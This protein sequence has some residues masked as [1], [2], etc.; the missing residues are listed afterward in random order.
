[1]RRYGF[2]I[3]SYAYFMTSIIPQPKHQKSLEGKF[4]LLENASISASAAARAKAEQLAN[5]LRPATGFALPL[6]EG[7]NGTIYLELDEKIEGAEAYELSVSSLG[8]QLKASSEAGL[9]YAIQSLRQLLPTSI[10]N[11]SKVDTVWS[12]PCLEIE[13]SP[14]FAWRGTH[15]DVSRHFMPL[16]FVKKFIDLMALHK[17]NVFHWHLTDDQG[18][19]LESKKYPRL[20]EVGA[21]RKQTMI[22]HGMQENPEFDGVPHGG[23]YTQDEAREIV[24]YG[25]ERHVT[26]M[27]EIELPGHAQAALAA[28]PEFGNTGEKLEVWGKWGI[29]ENVFNPLEPTILFLQEILSEV[30]SIFPSH[31]IHVGGD[32]CPKTQWE[33]SAAA[34]KRMRE[35]EI[36]DE[37]ALQSYFIG[38]MDK[39][40]TSKGRRLVGWDEILEGGLTENATVMSWRGEDGGIS[41]A[42]A[43]HDVIMTP[44]SHTY[45]DHYQSEQTE[46]EPLAIGGFTP[47][48]KVYAYEPIPPQL[49]ALEARHVLGSQAQHW[50][51]YMQVPSHVEYMAFPRLC[52]FGEVVWS[53]QS[54]RNYQDFL[55]RLTPHL[56][57]LDLLKVNYRK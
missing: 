6:I 32:E 8:V 9:F 17:L 26:V 5:F 16:E 1:V 39:F 25:L 33:Q 11:K 35:L 41:A 44:G 4:V 55:K 27:P 21:W 43:G 54:S 31:Y 52:A 7:S 28:Y 24:A 30:I 15:L 42:K 56:E 19:R 37:H 49:S 22:G 3:S 57:R 40:L 46:L 51:E 14:R 29:N 12:I 45:F 34:Q 47:L 50:T 10:F 23:F 2:F 18:W 38:R 36:P 53:S 20:T 48:E 13:D